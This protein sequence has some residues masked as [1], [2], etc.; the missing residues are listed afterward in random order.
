[1]PSAVAEGVELLGISEIEIGLLL[2]PAAQPAFQR[3][4]IERIE[5]AE[6]QGVVRVA[7]MMDD[8]RGRT[9]VRHR[10]D[11][12]GKADADDVL[13]CIDAHRR[14]SVS[15]ISTGTPSAIWSAMPMASMART[16]AP[17]R[18]SASSARR[19][20]S[21][22]GIACG[23][24]CAQRLC[25]FVFRAGAGAIAQDHIGCGRRAADAGPAM[26]DHRRRCVPAAAKFEQSLHMRAA[27]RFRKP[28]VGDVVHGQP[29]MA[30]RRKAPGRVDHVAGRKQGHD[31]RRLVHFHRVGQ[32]G[33][34]RDQNERHAALLAQHCGGGKTDHAVRRRNRSRN[35]AW[36]SAAASGVRRGVRRVLGGVPK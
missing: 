2:H 29:Q 16:I 11:G 30:L 31:M 36:A 8:E 14:T 9:F 4:V 23:A 18:P 17:L 13:G 26:H 33:E 28:F 15:G 3:A 5:G 22:L 12:G 20:M 7:R 25:D 35:S 24:R 32:G 6:G 21:L 10:H 27:G 34:R 19:T 1:M